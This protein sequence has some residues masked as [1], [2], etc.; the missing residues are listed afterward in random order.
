MQHHS[1]GNKQNENQMRHSELEKLNYFILSLGIP[2]RLD[3]TPLQTSERARKG[4][5]DR[6]INQ[7]YDTLN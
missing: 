3:I 2:I 7:L 6:K 1:T 4:I 5:Q